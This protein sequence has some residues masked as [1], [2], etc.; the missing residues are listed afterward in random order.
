[1]NRSEFKS[2][3]KQSI[4][5]AIDKTRSRV[6]EVISS[7]L[8][9]ELHGLG[10]TGDII[11]IDQAFD[12]IYLSDDLYWRVINISVKEIKPD[13]TIIFVR[14]G[15]PKPASFEETWN[16]PKGYGPFRPS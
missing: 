10:H 5:E 12:S 2:L 15:G 14:V 8:M 3:F 9:I 11:S 4:N 1:M 7:N 16:D 6:D 13:H